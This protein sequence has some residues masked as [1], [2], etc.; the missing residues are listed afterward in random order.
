MTMKKGDGIRYALYAIGIVCL[1]A[2]FIHII[3]N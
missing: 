3:S 1:I 2:G